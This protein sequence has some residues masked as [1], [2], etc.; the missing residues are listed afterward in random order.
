VSIQSQYRYSFLVLRYEANYKEA[1]D[2]SGAVASFIPHTYP[3][4]SRMR[5]SMLPMQLM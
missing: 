5:I 1:V 3:A 2:M 4:P